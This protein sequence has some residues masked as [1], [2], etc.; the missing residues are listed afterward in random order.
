MP[1]KDKCKLCGRVLAYG[2]LR[3]CWK[4]GQYFCL[5]CMVPDVTTGDTQRMTC[6]NCARRMVSPKVENKYSRLTSYLKFRKAF[7]DSVRLTLAQIDGIIGD[8]LPMEAYRSNDWWA[9]S[10]DRI[11]SK[12]WIEAG[13]RTVEVNL[14][15]GYVVFKRIENFPKA[16][17]T[18]ERSENHPEKPFQPAPAR[19]KRIR[20]PSK[21]KLAK[22]YARI[23]NIERQ[24]RNRLKR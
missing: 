1:F 24:R 14:K 8:N 16:T 12:A 13:W 4:C 20:K 23:K 7:T 21:T 10:P 19:I 9:N 5:D 2:Y 11:H 17:I 18:K 15:E 22:L 6:L 3:R